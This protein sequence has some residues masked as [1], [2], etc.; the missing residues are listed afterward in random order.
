MRD[1]EGAAL[2]THTSGKVSGGGTALSLVAAV[3]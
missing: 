2:D 3:N 1:C